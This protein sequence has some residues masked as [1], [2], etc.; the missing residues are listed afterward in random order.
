MNINQIAATTPGCFPALSHNL[1]FLS[2]STSTSFLSSE[3]VRQ[4]RSVLQSSKSGCLPFTSGIESKAFLQNFNHNNLLS[5][6]VMVAVFY[7]HKQNTSML[8]AIDK[9]TDG[10][11][12]CQQ[13]ALTTNAVNLPAPQH[14]VV[15]L[16][17]YCY[18]A[19]TNQ[20][21]LLGADTAEIQ[22]TSTAVTA[23]SDTGSASDKAQQ[24]TLLCAE[25]KAFSALHHKNKGRALNLGTNALWQDRYQSVV[26]CWQNGALNR[27]PAWVVKR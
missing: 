12:F 15:W 25:Q 23:F 22:K 6:I 21:D 8:C 7:R 13:S 17:R 26:V 5:R 24:T 16:C 9:G 20:G 14:P 19:I 11:T 10:R 2:T 4:Q 3:P 27:P 18:Y 1:Q